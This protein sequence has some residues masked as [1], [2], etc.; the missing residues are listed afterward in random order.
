MSESRVTGATTLA[1]ILALP[2]AA[3]VTSPGW[4]QEPDEI[5]VTTRKREESLQEVPIAVTVIDDKTLERQGITG[6]EGIASLSPSFIFNES[7]SQKDVR[8]AVRGLT[9]TRG[10]SNVAFLVDGIDVT[11]ESIGSAG[12]SLLVSQRLLTDV[13]RVEA[14]KGPQSALY[15]RAAFAGA[16]NYVTKNAPDAFQGQLFAELADYGEYTVSGTVGGPITDKLGFLVTGFYWDEQGQYTNV[17]SGD[18][19]GGGD[20]FGGSLTV[21]ANPTD[22]I[23]IKFR[24]ESTDETYKQ[25][26]RAR[27]LPDTTLTAE[28]LPVGTPAEIVAEAAEAGSY[29]YLSD[30]GN[31]DGAE[32]RLS[33]SILSGDERLGNTLELFRASLIASWDL[34]WGSLTSYTGYVDAT[35]TED[36]SLDGAADGRPDALVGDQ[37]VFNDDETE[38]VSQEIRYQSD[39][40]GPFRFTFG[41][42]YW[43]SKRTQVEKGILGNGC[44]FSSTLFAGVCA[45][46]SAI[47]VPWQAV[48]QRQL[49]AGDVNVRQPLRVDDDHWSVYGM[50]EWQVTDRWKLTVENRYVKE[51]QTVERG[52]LNARGSRTPGAFDV[53]ETCQLFTANLATSFCKTVATAETLGFGA[54]GGFNG[55]EFVTVVGTGRRSDT[56]STSYNTPKVT[57]EFAPTDDVLFYMS[58]GKGQKP[59]GI[60]V[61]GGASAVLD[62]DSRIFDSEELWA[63][64]IG[65]KTTWDGNFGSLLLNGSGFFQDYTDKQVSLRVR[66]VDGTVSRNTENAASAEVL[67]V[68][69]EAFW[70]TPVEGLSLSAAYTWLDTEFGEFSDIT[71][72]PQEILL[73]GNCTPEAGGDRVLGTSDDQCTISFAGN[74][75]EGAPEH[76]FY[77]AFTLKRPFADS[78]T[79]WLI[80]ADTQYQAERFSEPN[81]RQIYE[82]FWK[83]NVRG[84]L[85]SDSVEVVAFIDNVTDNSSIPSSGR[86]PDTGFIL[87][88]AVDFRLVDIGLLPRRRQFG[89]RFKYR[90]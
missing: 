58:A 44:D 56:V 1:A 30:F 24:L 52:V 32:I 66:E 46:P 13:S 76:A 23:S 4:A 5:V 12:A 62:I 50:L 57:L 70:R 60:D 20:G 3:S 11:S 71:D 63:Y 53:V 59:G 85:V 35:T 14:V 28:D 67:G 88:P 73:A 75:L 78:A 43:T 42:N 10:R 54:A 72:D 79:D 15:G 26:P 74:S 17:V 21:N 41:G 90:F 36:Y 87:N 51:E 33:E 8:L 61:L 82:D 64:E 68:E 6:L 25:R 65:A 19:V 37:W 81:N 45:T 2:M 48:F 77:A 7:S 47:S 18:D 16:I 29:S 86:V 39:L 89:I 34:Y 22:A 83:L 38:I 84:G 69:L 80:E 40:D 31:A 49:D 9:P 55:F 27:F